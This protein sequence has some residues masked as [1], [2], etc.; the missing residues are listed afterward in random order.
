MFT[1]RMGSNVAWLAVVSVD[2]YQYWG[3]EA[4]Y[5]DYAAGF[6]KPGGQ[7]GIVVPGDAQDQHPAGTFHSADWW[8][9]LWSQSE[10]LRVEHA[11]WAGQDPATAGDAPMLLEHESVGFTRI[12][13]R[14]LARP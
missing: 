10:L 1:N 14:R 5:V 11:A 3:C 4:G 8:R 7:L 9:G 13:A 12:V 2:S 6:V